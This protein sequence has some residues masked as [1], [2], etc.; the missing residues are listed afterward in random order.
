MA[1]LWLFGISPPLLK[2]FLLPLLFQRKKK[3]KTVLF[4]AGV[5]DSEFLQ[6]CFP[7]HV[8]ETLGLENA[9]FPFSL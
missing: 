3:C 2:Y 5:I 6:N 9:S 7:S 8:A 4:D 1:S